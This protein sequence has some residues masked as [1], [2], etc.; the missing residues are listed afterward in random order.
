MN[1]NA[2]FAKLSNNDATLSLDVIDSN[3]RTSAIDCNKLV[4]AAGPW[5]PATFQMLFPPSSIKFDPVISAGNWCVIENSGSY[6]EKAIAGVY[7]DAIVGH[8]LEFAGRNDHTIWATGEQTAT[9][10]VPGAGQV[11]QPDP[12]SLGKLKFYA[13]LYLK[14]Q[15]GGK[16]RMRV[17]GQGRAYRPATRTQLP[18]IAAVPACELSSDRCN[19]CNTSV[20]VNSGHDLTVSR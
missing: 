6:S 11:P 3:N 14:R 5:T 8:E 13:D 10:E 4:L 9:G 12:G 16:Q 20:F 1:T 7:F 19:D 18:I 2:V 15:H 17:I